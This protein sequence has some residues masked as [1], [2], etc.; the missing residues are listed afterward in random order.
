MGSYTICVAET[1]DGEKWVHAEIPER[2]V[3]KGY[4]DPGEIH[5]DHIKC[6]VPRYAIGLYASHWPLQPDDLAPSTAE[7]TFGMNY[8]VHTREEFDALTPDFT[9]AYY[10]DLADPSE[11]WQRFKRD[12]AD[13]LALVAADTPCRL[14][15]WVD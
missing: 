4:D 14:I 3:L 5:I 9:A 15:F 12:I 13:G 8:R 10:S 1:H 7:A 2:F 6:P 11:R